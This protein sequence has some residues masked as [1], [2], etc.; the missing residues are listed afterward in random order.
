MFE[1]VDY[2]RRKILSEFRP[3]P[4]AVLDDII[5]QVEEGQLARHLSCRDSNIHIIYYCQVFAH[6]IQVRFFLTKQ[7]SRRF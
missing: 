3:F 1:C 4:L 7:Q 2:D 5:G 6:D